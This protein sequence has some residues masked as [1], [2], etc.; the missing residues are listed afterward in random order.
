M[1]NVDSFLALPNVQSL[2]GVSGRTWGECSTPVYE[3]LHHEEVVS[4]SEDVAFVLAN[5][6]KVLAYSG[7]E[8][9]ACNYV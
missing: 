4:L 9:F 2:L 3:A 6:V 5:N 8:D 7:T 1:T